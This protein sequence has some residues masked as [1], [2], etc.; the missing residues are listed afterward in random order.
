VNDAQRVLRILAWLAILGLATL[1]VGTVM[2]RIQQE[3]KA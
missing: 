1:V 2:G 3:V